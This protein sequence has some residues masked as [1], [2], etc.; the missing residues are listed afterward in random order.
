MNIEWILVTVEYLG[1]T[2][3]MTFEI[4]IS[5]FQPQRYQRRWLQLYN[6]RYCRSGLW[7]V[8]INGVE[9]STHQ[10]YRVYVSQTAGQCIFVSRVLLYLINVSVAQ[11]NCNWSDGGRTVF[12]DWIYGNLMV[13]VCVWNCEFIVGGSCVMKLGGNLFGYEF[14]KR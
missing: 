3:T 12:C 2:E 1:L 7:F 5:L 4:L 6:W 9:Q 14:M 10:E 13:S 11:T 8:S